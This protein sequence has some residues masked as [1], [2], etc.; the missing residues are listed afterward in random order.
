V[1][2]AVTEACLLRLPDVAKLSPRT[3]GIDEH[4]FRSVRYFQDPESKSWTRFEPWMTTIVDL[5][6]GQVLG[7][8]DGRD[9]KGVGDLAL[10]PPAS[11]AAGR[12]GRGDR[13]LGRV[14]ESLEEAASPP[15]S[16]WITF[17]WSPWPTRP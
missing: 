5:D 12:A 7:V 10:R 15:P 16:R 8:V 1:R 6:T 9:H 2:A 11:V 13:P 3:L 14:P 17:I 4:R